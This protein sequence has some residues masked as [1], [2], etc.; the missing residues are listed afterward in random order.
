MD[1]AEREDR[2]EALFSNYASDVLAYGMRRGA[3]RVDAEDMMIETFVVCC[4]HLDGMPDPG[5]PWLIA[6]ARRVLA[7]QRRSR[8]RRSTLLEKIQRHS[9]RI[10]S[11]SDFPEHMADEELMGAVRK[12][13]AV[14]RES[15]FLVAWEGLTH[16][17][18]AQ[19]AGCSRSAFTRRF[20]HA[21]RQLHAHLE[22]DRTQRVV[23][24]DIRDA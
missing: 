24:S 14:D 17:E 19:V 13:S 22:R 18:A 6:V 16:E 11:P 12:L 4:R 7:N 20:R 3:S 21:R 1:Q 15:L 9:D 10:E 8:S 23:G 5:L 2:L